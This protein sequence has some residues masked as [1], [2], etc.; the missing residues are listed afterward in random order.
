MNLKQLENDIKMIEFLLKEIE[1]DKTNKK[2]INI[3][4]NKIMKYIENTFEFIIIY[5]KEKNK[6][7]NITSN[8]DILTDLIE[9]IKEVLDL[10][11]KIITI[12][13]LINIIKDIS[14][15]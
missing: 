12:K 9:I 13:E 3:L 7:I 14:L 6:E 2:N 5:S 10:N 8:I 4:N 15:K 11:L 1:G